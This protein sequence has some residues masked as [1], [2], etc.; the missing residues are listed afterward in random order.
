M[1]NFPEVPGA[2]AADEFAERFGGASVAAFVRQD[3]EAL[4]RLVR[5][6]AHWAEKDAF[7]G[8]ISCVTEDN[9]LI[10][11]GECAEWQQ[12]DGQDLSGAKDAS[13][14]TFVMAGLVRTYL[15]LLSDHERK[16]LA[17]EHAE[18]DSWIRNGFS[19]RLKRPDYVYFGLNMGWYWPA[20]NLAMAEGRHRRARQLLRQ[21]ERGL[22]QDVNS[23][24]SIKDRT[25]RGDRALW[26]QFTSIGEVLVSLETLRAVGMA[27]RTFV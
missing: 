21:L 14:S 10:S 8:T 25:T 2:D 26:Y 20:I 17:N 6:L 22:A 1:D 19:A 7:L 24:G 11:A 12:P 3:G 18:I 23:D 27:A 5:V 4:T 16:A 13:H 9:Y 15:A